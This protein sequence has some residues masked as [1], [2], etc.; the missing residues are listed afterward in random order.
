[1]DRLDAMKVFVTALDE[2]SL[3]GAG[4]KL[5]RSAAAVS[6]AISFL[7]AY[8]G[9]Q[10]LHRTTRVLKPSATGERYA[11]A[12]R[13][14]LA[15][16]EEADISVRDEQLVPRGTLSLAASVSSGE[17]V[18]RP[19]LNA[20]LEAYPA[21]TTRLYLCDRAV[22]LID[23]GIDI[24][25]RVDHLSDSA[26]VAIR[27]GETRRVVVAAP[28]YLA[29]H[30]RIQEP[31]DLAKHQIIA[32]PHFGLDSWSFPPL[33][34][35]SIPRTVRYTPKFILNSVRG[36]VASAVDGHGVTRAYSYHVAQHVQAGELEILLADN[37]N[38]PLPIHLITPPGRL[39]TRK[40]RAFVD[41][42]VPRLRSAFAHLRL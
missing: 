22:N 18:L 19:I 28:R 31:N 42:A 12:C 32:V 13:R 9:S 20:F 35:S 34:G 29:L 3:A 39:S 38:P 26:L 41:F 4:R 14:I 17:D 2:G 36:A 33:S 10:L 24:A 8:T 27:A 11:L 1:M 40:V 21:V 15:E 5:S 37:E 16:L 6:R 7:E 30:P 23:E 25:L